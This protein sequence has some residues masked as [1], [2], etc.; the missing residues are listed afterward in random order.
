[1]IPGREEIGR[2]VQ[3]ALL[4]ARGDSAG[5]GLFDTSFDGFWHSFAAPVLAAPIYA[6]LLAEQ[7]ARFGHEG[8]LG[9]IVL[10]ES[11]SYILDILTFPVLAIFLTKFLNLGARYVPLVVATNWATLPQVLLFLAA[12]TLG[13]LVAPLRPAL[14][15]F[16]MLATLTYQWFVVRTALGSTGGH[17]AAF[18]TL[19]LLV[20]L[21]LNR[22][23]DTLLQTG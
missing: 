23:A 13:T 16:A 11:V 7:Y 15:L 2:A 18:V 12:V 22:V 5:M 9:T 10:A 14:L 1:M 17:A 20:G 8:G 3:G 4:L 21:L 19:N 6:L